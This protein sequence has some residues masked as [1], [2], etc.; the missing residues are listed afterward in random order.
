M[1]VD[2]EKL[3]DTSKIWVYQSSR[4]FYPK[5]I[6]EI[7]QQTEG[8]LSS[9]KDDDKPIISSYKI[10][11]DRFLI[12]AVDQTL[13]SLSVPAIDDSVGFIFTLQNTYE[14]ELLDKLIVSF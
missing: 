4:K 13:E 5:E 8:F 6:L 12:F 2:F 10:M 9:W 3:P 14:V 1:L 7:T 11:F